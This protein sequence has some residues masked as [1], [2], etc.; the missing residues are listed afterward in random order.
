MAT[1]ETST[2]YMTQGS[3][4]SFKPALVASQLGL[5]LN[6]RFLNV[7]AGESRTPEFLSINPQGQLPYLVLNNDLS[8]GE[9]NAIAWYLA[10]G[11]T[12]MPDTAL[13]RAQAVQW[14]NYEQ[15]KLEAN[16]SPVRFFTYIVPELQSEHEDMIPVWRE[17]G[18]Q[19][20]GLLNNYLGSNDFITD[21]GYSVADIAVYGYTHLAEEGGFDFN[22][23]QN[24]VKWMDRVQNQQG[25]KTI[26]EL[27]TG[28]NIQAAA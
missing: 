11:T 13:A 25:Y 12:L 6:V 23:Y 3:G 4:N 1:H 17:R 21:Y 22:E 18:N 14:M 26:A 16:I 24:I 8:I 19:G 27:L 9:S 5:N 20:L 15:T 28:E 7:L 10:E 2:L